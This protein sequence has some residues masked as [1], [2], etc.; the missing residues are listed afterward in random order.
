MLCA[1][2]YTVCMHNLLPFRPLL[3]RFSSSSPSQGRVLI[4]DSWFGSVACALALFKHTIFA[5]MNV[6][7]AHRGYPKDDLLEVV[8]EIKGKSA[9]AKRLRNERRG[10][11][12]AFRQEFEVDGSRRVT[13]L[14]AGHNN[15]KVPLNLVC[16]FSRSRPQPPVVARAARICPGHGVLSSTT[17]RCQ[18]LQIWTFQMKTC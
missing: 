12:V 2:S 1:C 6:K 13:V 18:N 5:V 11:Q 8:G 17:K 10:K 16:T 14:A 7:T 4:A 15:K 3:L 9:E